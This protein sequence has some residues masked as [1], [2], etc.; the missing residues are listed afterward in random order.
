MQM[1]LGHFISQWLEILR[2]LSCQKL[3]CGKAPSCKIQGMS[4]WSERC[5]L[6]C[7]MLAGYS[8]L[9]LGTS[10]RV[11]ITLCIIIQTIGIEKYFE[12]MLQITAYFELNPC[13]NSN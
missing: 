3:E 4:E 2:K 6:H 11:Q 13:V 5:V 10:E 8:L 9:L 7:C 12:I 1:S